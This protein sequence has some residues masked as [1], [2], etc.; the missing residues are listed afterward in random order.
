VMAERWRI[1]QA[2]E[3]A[4]ISIEVEVMYLATPVDQMLINL[5]NGAS[6]GIRPSH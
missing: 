3:I 6:A 1:R 5:A 4:A 2:G